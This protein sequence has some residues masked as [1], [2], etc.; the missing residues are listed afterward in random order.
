MKVLTLSRGVVPIG[1][2]CGGAELAAYQ[3]ARHLA[4]RGHDVT[5]VSDFDDSVSTRING[6]ELVPLDSALQRRS[7]RLRGGFC[8]WILQHLIANVAVA[9]VGRRLMRDQRYDL[10]HAHGALSALLLTCFARIPVAYT[11]HDAPPWVCRYRH[12]WERALRRAIYRT[13]EVS[14]WRRV[15][16]VVVTLPSLRDELINRW[17]VPPS[18]VF[19]IASGMD[20]DIFHPEEPAKRERLRY[21]LFVG[22]LTSRKA[23]DLL[24]RAIARVPGIRCT[25]AGDGPM[26]S[27]L[28][29]LAEQLGISDRVRFL[30]SLESG[31]LAHLYANADLL[32]LPSFAETSPLVAAEAMACGTPVLATRIAGLPGLVDDF[33]TGFLVTPGDVGELAV[34]LRFLTRDPA[35]LTE[36]G[37]TAEQ[38]AGKRFGWPILAGEYEGVYRSAGRFTRERER[39][40]VTT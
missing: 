24:L 20:T 40:A 4:R 37:H 22:R 33:E 12:W 11:E 31:Q 30:G 3:L 15:D 27:Q 5:L 1:A 34:A 35:L 38:R 32:V 21:C 9:R 6:L 36:M 39:V 10:V 2:T 28:E 16:R 8:A 17:N 7:T 18:H 19:P 23:P 29:R 25:F 26:R 13:L 14:A